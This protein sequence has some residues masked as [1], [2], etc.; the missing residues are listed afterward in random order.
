M[1]HDVESVINDGEKRILVDLLFDLAAGDSASGNSSYEAQL[2]YFIPL[3]IPDYF[4]VEELLEY[5]QKYRMSSRYMFPGKP[6]RI[7]NRGL[8]IKL[9]SS[10]AVINEMATCESYEIISDSMKLRECILSKFNLS[11][12]VDKITFNKEIIYLTKRYSENL[13]KDKYEIFL[14]IFD[15]ISDIFYETYSKIS[16]Y[17]TGDSN[18]LNKGEFLNILEVYNIN[19]YEAT[20]FHLVIDAIAET[21]VTKNECLEYE[22]EF[23]KEWENRFPKLKYNEALGEYIQSKKSAFVVS[24]GNNITSLR[25]EN[26]LFKMLADVTVKLALVE[27][28]KDLYDL[29]QKIK[30]LTRE[31]GDNI[32]DV[33]IDC[34]KATIRTYHLAQKGDYSSDLGNALIPYR[35]D[36]M[37]LRDIIIEE[38]SVRNASNIVQKQTRKTMDASE[39]ELL[40]SQKDEEIYDLKRELEYYENIKQQ[41]FKAEVL[42]YNRALTDLFRKL[43]D[44]KYNSPLNELYLFANGLKEVS[45]ESIKGILQNLVFIMSTMNIIPYETGNVGKRVKFYDD[46][47]NIVYAVDDSKVKDGINKGTQIYPG[48]KY[49]DTEL[50]LPK[51]NIEE[52]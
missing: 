34:R 2:E 13:S 14:S 45:Q 8:L 1:G 16:T 20:K 43:C 35:S 15:S 7:K 9:F 42:Q 46:E 37:Y 24:Y 29:T 22:E 6:E 31:L 33:F 47:A 52:D 49:K 51:V 21:V 3:I 50:V 48:W 27:G 41:E 5:G 38:I 32:K 25:N 4:S 11:N 12:E 26:F 17:V 23:K 10:F 30:V 44:F 18:V 39:Y 19:S 28:A 40:I 36:L